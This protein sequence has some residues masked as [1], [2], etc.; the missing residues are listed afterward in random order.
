MGGGLPPPWY[1]VGTDVPFIKQKNITKYEIGICQCVRE[2]SSQI[3]RMPWFV[4]IDVS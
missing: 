4:N 3:T 2:F 1:K